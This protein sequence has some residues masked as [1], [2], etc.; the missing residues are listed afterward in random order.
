MP[1][2]L[3]GVLKITATKDGVSL[4]ARVDVYRQ[5]DKKSIGG[6]G[7]W[8]GNKPAEYTLVPDICYLTVYDSKTK[9][10]KE[11]RDI[12][13]LPGQTVEKSIAF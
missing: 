10:K 12:K 8:S 3:G 7:T 11:I 6:K 9:D 1:L 5:S 4:N 13:I 2:V